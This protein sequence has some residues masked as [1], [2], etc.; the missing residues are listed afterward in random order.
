MDLRS[1]QSRQLTHDCSSSTPAPCYSPNAREIVFESDREGTQQLYVMGSDGSRRAPPQPRR[2]PLFDAGV[3]AARRLHRLHQADQRR[4]PDRR[5]EARRHRRA[6]PDRGLPQRRP[7]LG[8]QRPRPDVLPREPRRAGR[9]G[10]LT[11]DITG[12][13][14]RQVPTPSFAS[15]PAWSPLLADDQPPALRRQPPAARSRCTSHNCS[16]VHRIET[17]V[18]S[19]AN[20][21]RT[22]CGSSGASRSGRLDCQP[23]RALWILLRRRARFWVLDHHRVAYSH[24]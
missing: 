15:D 7:D 16:R 1:K 21:Q 13:N 10:L 3:V 22:N 19:S 4:L 8:A 12:Y 20:P 18:N 2:R 24:Q 9:T 6:H 5:D 14:E 23:R 17:P 11:V